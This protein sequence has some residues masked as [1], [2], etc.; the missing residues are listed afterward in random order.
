MSTTEPNTT[1]EATD[2]ATAIPA[3][4]YQVYIRADAQRI[5]DAITT[6]EWTR[7]YGY[8]AAL[9]YELRPGG[10]FRALPSPEM[11]EHGADGPILDGEVVEVR[12]PHRLVQTW[13][14]RWHPEFAAEGFTTVTYEIEPDQDG[15]HKLTVTHDVTGT[16][17]VAA[18]ID[19]GYPEFGGGW[20]Q[21]LSDLKTLLETGAPLYG[22]GPGEQE[23][24]DG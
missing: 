17:K 6:P 14:T 18:L 10:R 16:P 15:V 13:R 1:Q 19:G 8:Q 24:N 5:W 11:I 12:P 21:I 7:R 3:R 4:V 22:G 2:P 9:E 20:S 23:V